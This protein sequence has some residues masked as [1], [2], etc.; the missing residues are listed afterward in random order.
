MPIRMVDDPN[1]QSDNS[2]DN[3][4]GGGGGRFPGGGGGGGIFQLLPLLF[5]LIRNPIGLV[6]VLAIGGFLY[7]KGGCSGMMEQVSSAF[8]TGGVLDPK[9]FDKAPI[10]ESTDPSKTNLPEAVSLL[11]FAPARQNQGQQGSCV[12]WSSAYA[13]RSILQSS[14]TGQDPNQAAFSPS[15]LYNQIGLEGCQGSYIIRAM[16]NM[17]QVGSVPFNDFPYTDQDCSRQPNS[18][19]K[20][21]A[22]QFR[23]LGFT[24]LTD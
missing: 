16:E 12:A 7:F 10:Y 6:I 17:T 8:S 24:R 20:Q 22:K 4:G 1:D 23:M 21:E 19:L 18:S 14:T 11:K 13:A 9:E 3:P 2:N 15:F 5:G